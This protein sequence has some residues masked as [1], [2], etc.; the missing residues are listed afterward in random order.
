MF[1]RLKNNTETFEIRSFVCNGHYSI[2]NTSLFCTFRIS[3][4]GSESSGWLHGT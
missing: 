1:K 4:D 3:K 2:S